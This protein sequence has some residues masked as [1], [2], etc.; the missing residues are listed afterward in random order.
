[1]ELQTHADTDFLPRP[2]K[3]F[4]RIRIYIQLYR[5]IYTSVGAIVAIG[6]GMATPTAHFNLSFFSGRLDSLLNAFVS[7][8]VLAV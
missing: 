3:L 5:Y 4:F 6:I 1:M 8:G 7:E 2:L